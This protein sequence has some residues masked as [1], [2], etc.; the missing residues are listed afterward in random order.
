MYVGGLWAVTPGTLY[1]NKPAM[2]SSRNPISAAVAAN[3]FGFQ[4][5]ER[6]LQALSCS[7]VSFQKSHALAFIVGG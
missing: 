2:V 6:R 5:L 7:V 3:A 4:T 1:P